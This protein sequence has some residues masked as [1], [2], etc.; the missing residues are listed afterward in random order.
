MIYRVLR[1]LI[2]DVRT[3]RVVRIFD[4]RSHPG[5]CWKAAE[6]ARCEFGKAF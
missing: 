6:T 3:S 2:R 1:A 4:L 5:D